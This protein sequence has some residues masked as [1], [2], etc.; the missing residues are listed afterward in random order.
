VCCGD[1]GNVDAVQI[2]KK[3][4]P[5]RSETGTSKKSPHLLSL[6][7]ANLAIVYAYHWKLDD[8]DMQYLRRAAW[9]GVPVNW[10]VPLQ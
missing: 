6:S 4:R 7:R 8:T 1:E 3:G 5:R 9:P 10:I 2:G